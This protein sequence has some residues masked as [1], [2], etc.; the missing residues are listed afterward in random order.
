VRDA[1]ARLATLPADTV[2]VERAPLGGAVFLVA[3]ASDGS[4]TRFDVDG[5]KAPLQPGELTAALH[6]FGPLAKLER[7]SAGTI[8]IVR[9]RRR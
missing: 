5:R 1:V 6:R 2:R 7:L 4:M 9:T 3:I 8:T